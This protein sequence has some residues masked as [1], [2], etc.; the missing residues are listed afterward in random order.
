[1]RRC[2]AKNSTTPSTKPLPASVRRAGVAA[3][4]VTCLRNRPSSTGTDPADS[5]G[6]PSTRP[7]PTHASSTLTDRGEY[8]A[9][10]PGGT[11][12]P[13][14]PAPAGSLNERGR[15]ADTARPLDPNRGEKTMQ[16]H[17][18]LPDGRIA[19][20]T[21]QGTFGNPAHTWTIDG[22][23]DVYVPPGE[24]PIAALRQRYAQAAVVP[25][26]HHTPRGLR[27]V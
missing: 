1:M 26:N 14:P 20:A 6:G 11:D 27:L 23:P 16:A 2:A 13:N 19:L 25:R 22:M 21:Y 24:T 10:I 12:T 4:R 17:I 18:P 3:M 7:C 8:T 9:A 15:A 5:A